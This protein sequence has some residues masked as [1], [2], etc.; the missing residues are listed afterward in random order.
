VNLLESIK[1]EREAHELIINNIVQEWLKENATFKVGFQFEYK[2]ETCTVTHIKLMG[3][4][5]KIEEESED[6]NPEDHIIYL[7][8]IPQWRYSD[9]KVS[10]PQKVLRR[11]LRRGIIRS[12]NTKENKRCHI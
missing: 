5:Y 4:I 1:K 9:F 10:W 8:D 12:L 7:I 3:D 2:G 6:L 11:S